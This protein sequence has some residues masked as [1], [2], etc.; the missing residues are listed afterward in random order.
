VREVPVEPLPQSSEPSAPVVF[1]GGLE[2]S[3]S[4]F[5]ANKYMI[6]V[7]LVVAALVAAF[8]LLR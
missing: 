2:T 3:Q 7:L 5:S 8:F 4:W 6:G 1:S